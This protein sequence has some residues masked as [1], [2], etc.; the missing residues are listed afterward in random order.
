MLVTN[1][2]LAMS[3]TTDRASPAPSPSIWRMR[4][5]TAAAVVLGACKLGFSAAVLAFGTYRLGLSAGELQT[6]AFVTLIFGA[7]G[8]LYVLRERRHMWSSRPGKWV[9]AASATDVVIV[10]ALALSG[11][12]MEP[13]PWRV[14]AA[15][16]VAAAGLAFVL[17]QVKLPV[18]AAFKAG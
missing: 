7:Q 12:L 2:F 4:N 5:I 17:D 3:L 10:S 1:D 15:V 16:F 18:K 14:L 9:L 13:L 8:L 11:T 6:L